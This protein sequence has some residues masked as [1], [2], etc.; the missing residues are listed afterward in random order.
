MISKLVVYRK[1]ISKVVVDLYS[2]PNAIIYAQIICI[3]AEFFKLPYV[4]VLHGGGLPNLIK[5][6]PRK[7]RRLLI[8]AQ[9]V[10]ATS[11]FL[12]KEFSYIRTIDVIPNAIEIEL[13][14]Y[15]EKEKIFPRLLFLRSFHKW[16]RPQDAILCLNEVKK[17]CPDATLT[18]AGWDED[19][20]LG[21]CIQ[22]VN[23]LYLNDSV[24][25]VGKLPKSKIYDLSLDHDI[26]LHTML[27]DN[28]PITL[29]EAMALG[30][31]IVATD[32]GGISSVLTHQETAMLV[33]P[34]DFKEMAGA[35]VFYLTHQEKAALMR[36]Q[37]RAIVEKFSWSNILPMWI[38]L[39]Q[40]EKD[41][42]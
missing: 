40:S 35:V 29:L 41:I 16:T 22:L 14:R 20:S 6:D 23:N 30:L 19:G 42:S 5:N 1:R 36:K 21:E 28:L 11:N 17:D 4:I 12:A 9:S 37:A 31:S 10:I 13:Y 8:K 26:F 38:N 25:F 3:L 2:G 18:L 33:N 24:N 15:Q 7:L 39:L 27:V 34:G 32:V